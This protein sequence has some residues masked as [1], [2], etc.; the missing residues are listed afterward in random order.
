MYLH[1]GKDIT[2]PFDSVIAVIDMDTSTGSKHTRAF[3]KAAEDKGRVIVVAEE[4]PKSAVICREFDGD[5]VYICQLSAKTL[6]KRINNNNTDLENL[7]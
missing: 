7:F 1:L 6:E 5:T 3:L 2:V 4:L